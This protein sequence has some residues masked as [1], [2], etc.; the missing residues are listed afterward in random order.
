MPPTPQFLSSSPGEHGL[1]GCSL[2]RPHAGG[3]IGRLTREL[4]FP[5]ANPCAAAIP[6]VLWWVLCCR[7]RDAV[8]PAAI[9][10]RKEIEVLDL[11]K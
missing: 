5:A 8:Y 10:L 9:C 3:A 4:G 11:L 6:P 1:P 2:G 7:T